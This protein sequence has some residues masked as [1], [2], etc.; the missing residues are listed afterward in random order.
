MNVA[1]P[2][3]NTPPELQLPAN[4]TVEGNTTGGAA[5]AYTVTATDAEDAVAPTPSCTPATGSLLPLGTNTISCTRDRLRRRSAPRARS[6]SRSSTRRTRSLHGMP[7]D[8]S[9]TT[10]DPSGTTLTYTPPTA[11]DIV[12]DTPGVQCSPVS[13]STIPVGDTTVTCTAARRHREHRERLVRRARHARPPTPPPSDPPDGA[14][15]DDPVGASAGIV[16]NGSR[17]RPGQGLADARRQRPSGPATALLTVASCDGGRGGPDGS[18]R[19]RQSN[20][21]WMGHVDTGGLTPGCYQ[22]VASVDGQAFGSFRMDVRGGTSPTA[23]PVK[24]HE[25]AH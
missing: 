8:V 20:G 11:T 12:D 2:V 6:T 24:S 21:R 4:S 23:K 17:S 1:T 19:H 16:V 18:A 3:E 10:T 5:A 14:R 15:W 13:G 25:K 7:G 22:V 9:L